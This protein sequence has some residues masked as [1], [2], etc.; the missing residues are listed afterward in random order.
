MAQYKTRDPHN[1]YRTGVLVGNYVED[2]FGAELAATFNETSTGPTMNQIRMNE[3][4]T[5]M[6]YD[7]PKKT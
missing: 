7:A 3:N 5:L 4:N 6:V 2:K 1:P